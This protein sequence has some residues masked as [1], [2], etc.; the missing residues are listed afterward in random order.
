MEPRVFL[1]LADLLSKGTTPAEYRTAVSRAYYSLYNAG[2]K[3][4]EEMG[5][6]VKTD[7]KGHTQVQHYLNNTG[8]SELSQVSS[9]LS[10][11]QTK[12]NKADY[13]L[14]D[15]EIENQRIALAAVSQA[16]RMVQLL[17]RCTAGPNRSAII[18][19]IADYR[20]KTNQ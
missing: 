1:D 18:Q 19:A 20:V 9:Q 16:T 14:T 6:T 12:R 8:E 7:H 15:V 13:R 17:E 11:L 4:L 2:V 10:S 5:F 3:A